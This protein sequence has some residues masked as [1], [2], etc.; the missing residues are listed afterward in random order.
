M[1]AQLTPP[2]ETSLLRI[3]TTTRNEVLELHL[4]GEMDISTR[5]ELAAAFDALERGS[6]TSVS[7]DL[8]AL[9]FC[10]ASGIAELVSVRKAA[11]LTGRR[12]ATHSMCPQ[13]GRL[14][15]ITGTA[16][17]LGAVLPR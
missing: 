12:L 5:G 7:V 3:G 14:L 1:T 15:L 13:V 4:A 9:E 8:T 11:A 16:A 10:D 2:P 17:F 6:T